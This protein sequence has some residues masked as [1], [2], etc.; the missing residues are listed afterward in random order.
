VSELARIE[1]MDL[2]GARLV[3]VSGEIDLS[4]ARDV[5]ESIGG[6]VPHDASLV[7]VDLSETSYL[8]SAGIAM[9]FRLAQ[10]LSYSRQELRLVVPQDAPIRAVLELTNLHQVIPVQEAIFVTPDPT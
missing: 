2:D 4:N 6:A 9:I 5:M 1:A 8:D 7:I 3:R 10:R